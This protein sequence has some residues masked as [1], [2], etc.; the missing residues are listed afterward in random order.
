[1]A[2][3]KSSVMDSAEG[4]RGRRFRLDRS[5]ANVTVAKFRK[6]SK[7]LYPGS[8]NELLSNV[9][10]FNEM[11]KGRAVVFSNKADSLLLPKQGN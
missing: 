6:S 2:K 7:W 10:E 5:T 1:M 8:V 4:G 9:N 3:V 11:N